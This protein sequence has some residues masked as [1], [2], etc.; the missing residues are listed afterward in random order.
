MTKHVL[1]SEEK[2]IR[3]GSVF[4]PAAPIREKD[5]FMGRREQVRTVMDAI[6]QRGQHVLI[7]GE[8]GVGK[9]SLANVL[10]G[11]L[12]FPGQEPIIAP[13]INCDATDD[14]SSTWR[15]I[16]RQ[17]RLTRTTPAFGFQRKGQPVDV[18]MLD[19][20]PET[21]T[22]E[23]VLSTALTLSQAYLFIPIIDE[24]DR[25]QEEQATRQF[26]DTIKA[27]SDQA[28]KTTLVLVGVAGTVEEL[29]A[30]HH[31]VE[32]ALVQVRMPRMSR[33]ELEQI[34]TA[35]VAAVGMTVEAEANRCIATLSQGLPHYTH[36]LGLHSARQAIDSGVEDVSSLHVD[37]AISK[38]IEG[39]QQT[40]MRAYHKAT[41]SPRSDNLYSQVLL[42]CALAKADQLGYFA[43]ADVREPMSEIMG[44]RYEIAAFSRHLADFCD[45]NRGPVLERMGIPRR[46]R[47][48]FR[49][50]LLQ[51]FV[52]MQG[53]ANK[54]I[55]RSDLGRIEQE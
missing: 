29:I 47:F 39:S 18:S 54:L 13:H 36:L 25:L 48:R 41:T 6:N 7:Y 24:F 38:A 31:S 34:V 10:A 33:Q 52:I 49:N 55:D 17:I 5:V 30:E 4:S 42:A 11:F 8:R 46:Y 45:E 28:G 19:G 23:V 35:G 9:T 3:L 53:L 16:F 21:I 15:K 12:A 2:A 37:A 20:L 26:T 43:A 50:P 14:Y 1:T 27:L 22:P 44:K 40:L 32:R 51:P